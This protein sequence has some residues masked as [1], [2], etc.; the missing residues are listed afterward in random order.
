M[1]DL[2]IT[3][4]SGKNK[5]IKDVEFTEFMLNRSDKFYYWLKG[6]EDYHTVDLTK[7][8]NIKLNLES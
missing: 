7:V 1:M 6:S 5:H 2:Y 3:Y 8:S 4:K